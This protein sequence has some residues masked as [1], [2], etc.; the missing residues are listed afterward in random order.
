MITGKLLTYWYNNLKTP[1]SGRNRFVVKEISTDTPQKFQ[2]AIEDALDSIPAG[3]GY[4]LVKW[5]KRMFVCEK[6]TNKPEIPYVRHEVKYHP[7]ASKL[8]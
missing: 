6:D 5:G 3:G 4:V 1:P 2:S 8:D 7:L